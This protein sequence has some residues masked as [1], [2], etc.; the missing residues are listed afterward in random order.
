MTDR[1][2]HE[3]A[4]TEA[5]SAAHAAQQQLEMAAYLFH[6]LR[7]DEQAVGGVLEIIEETLKI[8]VERFTRRQVVPNPL[9]A[10]ILFFPF[11]S[12]VRSVG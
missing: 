8:F 5:A 6:E 11:P 1:R 9:D 10:V 7:N 4:M 2:A 3:A 12:I